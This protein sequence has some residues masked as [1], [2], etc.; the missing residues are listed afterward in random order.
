MREPAEDS[1]VT[2]ADTANRG[3]SRF[4]FHG[5]TNTLPHKLA[6]RRNQNRG[7]NT[8]EPATNSLVTGNVSA[9]RAVAIPFGHCATDIGGWAMFRNYHLKDI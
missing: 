8:R 9:G 1:R 2:E 3:C 7:Q 5:A 6:Y 4:A